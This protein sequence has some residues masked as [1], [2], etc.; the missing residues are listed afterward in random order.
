MFFG[1]FRLSGTCLE[2]WLKQKTLRSGLSFQKCFFEQ[3]FGDWDVFLKLQDW[4]FFQGTVGVLTHC[5]VQPWS[6]ANYIL[7]KNLSEGVLERLRIHLSRKK[8]TDRPLILL[9]TTSHIP[10]LLPAAKLA[11][12]FDVSPK[13]SRAF[14]SSLTSGARTSANLGCQPIGGSISS[15]ASKKHPRRCC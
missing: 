12:S 9:V 1:C 6:A 10:H 11:C 8:N 3:I 14:W 2:I 13:R 4:V 15:K 5:H 7:R